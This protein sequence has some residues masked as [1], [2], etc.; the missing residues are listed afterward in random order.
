MGAIIGGISM[1]QQIPH[2]KSKSHVM[3]LCVNSVQSC[4]H[5]FSFD[6]SDG[7]LLH[8]TGVYVSEVMGEVR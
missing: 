1:V 5:Q 6:Y 8:L 2:S 3:L 7:A 4:L